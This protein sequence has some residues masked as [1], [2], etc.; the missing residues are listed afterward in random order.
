MNLF[1]PRRRFHRRHVCRN[2]PPI[3]DARLP[4][5]VSPTVVSV[6]G[7]RVGGPCRIQRWLILEVLLR[8]DTDAEIDAVVSG[9]V[10]SADLVVR[11]TRLDQVT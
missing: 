8:S 5:D 9:D 11:D 6:R 10:S 4:R 2:T 3:Q 7:T 1:D